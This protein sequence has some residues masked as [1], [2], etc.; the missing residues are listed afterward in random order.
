LFINDIKLVNFK[1]YTDASLSFSEGFNSFI[2]LNGSGKTNLLDAIYM[3]CMTKSYFG[4]S[5]RQLVK[6]DEIFFRMASSMNL[7]DQ[8]VS[9]VVKYQSGQKKIVEKNKVAYDKMAEHIGSFP[10]VMIAPDD[11][12][13]ILESGETRRRFVDNVLCQDDPLYLKHLIQYNGLLKQRNAALKQI[14]KA[15]TQ[16]PLLIEIYDN[17]LVAPCHYI[18]KKRA[19]FLADFLPV[20]KG[21]YIVISDGNEPVDI[22]YRSQINDHEYGDLLKQNFEKDYYLEHTST[23]IHRDD[24]VFEFGGRALKK[25]ASQ[26]QRKSFLIS[27]KLA[28][29]EFLRRRKNIKPILLLDD[30]FDKLDSERVARVMSLLQEDTFGQVFI[31]DTDRERVR[32]IITTINKPHYEFTV[33][34]GVIKR[35]E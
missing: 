26:G 28:Q 30:I 8:T 15:R 10:I 24:L 34:K 3:I 1:N 32:K 19:E 16:D 23:G 31:S 27:L 6:N 5:D 12:K 29:Y 2:G 25:I 11:I 9:L 13:L 33:N 4:I 7:K 18:N 35:N 22:T 21:F 14:R 17:Q 20:F